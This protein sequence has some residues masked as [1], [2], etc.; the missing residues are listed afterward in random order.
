MNRYYLFVPFLQA[1][2]VANERAM[3]QGGAEYGTI[4]K[5]EHFRIEDEAK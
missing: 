3:L 2:K 5:E 1:R 4:G